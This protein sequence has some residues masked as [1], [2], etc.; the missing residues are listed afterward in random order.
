M[1]ADDK[2]YTVADFSPDNFIQN[3]KL[4]E[5][6]LIILYKSFFEEKCNTRYG[7][8][9]NCL[10]DESERTLDPT[11]W[12]LYKKFERNVKLIQDEP[13]YYSY[14]ETDN[15]KLCFYLKYWIY[16]QLIGK[17]ITNEQFSNFINLW[18][19]KKKV[20]CPSCECKFNVT[21]FSNVK[22]LK[23]AYDYFLFLNAY[24]DTTTI[25][26]HIADKH[27]CRY[28]EN[29]KAIYSSLETKCIKDNAPYCKEFIDNKLPPIEEDD[30]SSIIC[31]MVLSSNPG[32]DEAFQGS[33]GL[34][35]KLPP[36]IIKS[37]GPNV[38]VEGTTGRTKT[39]QETAGPELG[40][41]PD[42]ERERTLGSKPEEGLHPPGP[43]LPLKTED[44]GAHQ[45]LPNELP[46]GEVDRFTSLLGT[47]S[48]G[49]ESPI[50]TI[51]SASFVGI[52]SIIF[53]LYKFTPLR[54]VLDPRI[55]KTKH[56]LKDGVQGSNELQSHD[57][58]FYPPDEDINRY[59]IAYQSR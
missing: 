35:H 50:K 2:I 49:N 29:T 28:I 57:Y 43:N 46:V 16:D 45:D 53:L 9:S 51:T 30:N 26:K 55:R 52:P 27:Y 21:S 38:E 18:N 12:E 17:N 23:R 47:S 41:A 44:Y 31:N 59:N 11:L 4:D 20:K 24:K 36:D 19:E 13:E 37:Q 10:S 56:M 40:S 8:Y 6:K 1:D 48:E 32:S 34:D 3:S 39:V 5:T 25:S 42:K 7:D 22:Q 33:K 58:D 54:T 15:K 14:W